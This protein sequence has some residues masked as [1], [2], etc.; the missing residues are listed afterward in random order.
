MMMMMR[1][2]RS[3]RSRV[4]RSSTN[5]DHHQV[6]QVEK[7]VNADLIVR[8]WTHAYTALRNNLTVVMEVLHLPHCL[9][10]SIVMMRGFA[11]ND[12]L[13]PSRVLAR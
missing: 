1:R 4:V 2:R 3:R 12:A 6:R 7:E 10:P 11:T 9:R 13:E 5:C 8:D